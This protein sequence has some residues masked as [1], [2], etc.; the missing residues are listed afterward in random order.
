[1]QAVH[2][3][4]CELESV[5][6]GKRRG[7]PSRP[8]SCPLGGGVTRPGSPLLVPGRTAQRGWGEVGGQAGAGRPDPLWVAGDLDPEPTQ[9]GTLALAVASGKWGEAPAGR[10]AR[11]GAEL[12]MGT[13]QGTE[14]A[15]WKLVINK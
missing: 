12:L 7:C 2:V 14:G 13:R 15:G 6:C 1:M 5:R 8:P 3:Y 9:C 4:I 11:P 10:L